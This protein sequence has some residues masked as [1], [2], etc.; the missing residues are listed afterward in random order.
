MVAAGERYVLAVRREPREALLALWRAEAVGDATLLGNHPDVTAIN[1][2][3][4]GR[5][6][7][8]LAQQAGVDLGIGGTSREQQY[9]NQDDTTDRIPSKK[10]ASKRGLTTP[11][12]L[13]IVR[14]QDT[15]VLRLR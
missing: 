2:G 10:S 13:V 14:Y 12:G 1:K 5:R 7:I 8:G 9:S 6:D 11:G 4:L 15:Y 3:N